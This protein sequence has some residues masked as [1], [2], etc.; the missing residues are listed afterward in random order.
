MLPTAAPEPPPPADG[1][2]PADDASSAAARARAADVPPW[3]AWAAPAA[4]VLGL[5]LGAVATILVDVAAGASNEN[6]VPPAI[7]IIG[8]IVFD[9]AFVVAALYFASRVTRPRAGDFGFRRVGLKR[10]LGAAI[11]AVVAYY[12]LTAIYASIF[13]LKGADKLPS[14]LGVTHSTAALI[15]A[16]AFVCVIAPVAEEFFFR[17]FIFG[18][19][20]R[21]SLRVGGRDLG[22]WVAA[23]LTGILF[24]L[25]HTGSA[26][27]QYLV[28]L[29][30]LGF[31]LCLLR[32]RTGSLYPC[33]AVHSANNAL[34]LGVN[35]LNWTALEITGLIAASWLVVAAITGPLGARTAPLR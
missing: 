9:L 34:A 6:H 33:I 15:A 18:A 19:L 5:G 28:P 1:A 8:D 30:F 7:S 22:V 29:G 11:L 2:S 26:S 21:L 3:P 35:Q 16:S 12:G 14:D 20:R 13:A 17:G 32:W 24:G 4:V 25:A 23:V 27:S 10:G 31:V